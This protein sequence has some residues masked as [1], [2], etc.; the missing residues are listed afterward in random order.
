[1]R[2]IRFILCLW[3]TTG[4]A[5]SSVNAESARSTP[6][7][8]R[9]TLLK[10]PLDEHLTADEFWLSYSKRLGL[11]AR[12]TMVISNSGEIVSGRTFL[13][14]WQYHQGI[15]VTDGEFILHL[16]NA[17]VAYGT[18]RVIPGAQLPGI[19]PTVSA[20][21][22]I[23]RAEQHLAA[24]LGERHEKL[25]FVPDGAP[26]LVLIPWTTGAKR[27]IH[28]LAYRLKLEVAGK[29]SPQLIDVDARTGR[30]LRV[31][32]HAS[33]VEMRSWEKSPH[34]SPA[35]SSLSGLSA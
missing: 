5:H 9:G 19:Q 14:Y 13:R 22:A 32:P 27:T 3:V 24:T 6:H 12:D 33:S 29:L 31:E 28:R 35:D 10:V 26:S 25:E 17:T 2:L 15:R 8:P 30:V 7:A 18:G 16:V 11:D 23:E 1:M 4:I 34:T 21:A 20:E